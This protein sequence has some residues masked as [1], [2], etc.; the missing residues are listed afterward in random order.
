[1]APESSPSR[2]RTNAACALVL[3]VTQKSAK[4]SEATNSFT[5]D[6]IRPLTAPEIGPTSDFRRGRS[7]ITPAKASLSSA[8][9]STC[10][11]IAAVTLV[12]MA[13]C[14]CGEF[15]SGPTVWM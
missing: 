13:A 10:C 3:A 12:A 9:T 2:R 4:V 14:T 6:S 5:C 11:W 8:S 1:M 15:T 7:V